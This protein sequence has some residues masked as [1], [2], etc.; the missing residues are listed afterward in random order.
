[1]AF[2]VLMSVLGS[3]ITVDSASKS[4]LSIPALLLQ[5]W[6]SGFRGNFLQTLCIFSRLNCELCPRE[7]SDE[8]AARKE[9]V[10]RSVMTNIAP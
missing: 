4:R 1:M 6:I 8:D 2:Q 5:K 10:E 7:R 9:D 3:C